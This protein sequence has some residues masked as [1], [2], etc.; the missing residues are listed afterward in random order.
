MF[1]VSPT[2]GVLK[3]ALGVTKCPLHP[4]PGG[5]KKR[6]RKTH[7]RRPRE[8]CHGAA[9][10]SCVSH[11]VVVATRYL[12]HSCLGSLYHRATLTTPQGSSSQCPTGGHSRGPWLLILDLASSRARV[13]RQPRGSGFSE[14][15]RKVSDGAS[16]MLMRDGLSSQRR[17]W[18]AR[19][20]RRQ[21]GSGGSAPHGS[22]R[23]SAGSG[24]R[25]RRPPPFPAPLPSSLA[26]HT[27]WRPSLASAFSP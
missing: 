10:L 1:P 6:R 14:A 16:R 15:P 9:P 19:G 5:G 11:L 20:R 17:P 8:L 18:P 24:A 12:D 27:L 26:L 7:E 13:S 2:G 23:A 21:K 25:G 22:G 4:S 3:E